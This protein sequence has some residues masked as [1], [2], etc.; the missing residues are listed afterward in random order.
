MVSE[1]S[2]KG[3]VHPFIFACCDT[4]ITTDGAIFWHPEDVNLEAI[5]G[6]TQPYHQPVQ[7]RQDPADVDGNYHEFVD[8][9]IK[10]EDKGTTTDIDDDASC[11][12]MS[13]KDPLLLDETLRVQTN[14]DK[15][16]SEGKI[17]ECDVKAV[18]RSLRK[19][20]LGILGQQDVLGMNITSEESKLLGCFKGKKY[21]ETF[22]CEFCGKV[23][24]GKERAYQFY[25]H[26]NRDHTH[27]TTFKCD[28][29]SK[30]FWGDRELLAHRVQHGDQGHICHICGQ[31]FNSN[32]NLKVHLLIH[33]PA[34]EHICRYCEKPF[35]RKDHLT[36]HERIHTGVRPYQC[37]WCDSGYPQKH[38]LKLHIRKCPILRQTE[39]KLYAT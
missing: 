33:D 34:R 30:E 37:Q 24:K 27:E 32:K 20:F 2:G 14:K 29:C 22:I 21:P 25:Y 1:K 3:A 39:A 28:V 17:E 38:Q 11:K 6:S 5:A 36:V 12:V 4:I 31:S 7:L 15:C 8:M 23:F 19:N 18:N 26:R 10:W 13:E 16:K 35:R 9:T